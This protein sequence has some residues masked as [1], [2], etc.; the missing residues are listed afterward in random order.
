MK[1]Y[2]RFLIATFLFFVAL[3]IFDVPAYA[4]LQNQVYSSTG[5]HTF[6]VPSGI[7]EITVEAWGGGGS[8]GS[9]TGSTNRAS[10]GGGGAYARIT[11]TVTPNQEITLYVGAGSS[12]TSAGGDSWFMNTATLLAKGGTSANSAIIGVG[13]SAAASNG[14]YTFSGGDGAERAPG[15]SGGGGSS[16]GS[17][18]NGNN[19]NG[20]L[21]GAAPVGG[22]AGGNGLNSAGPGN[23]GGEPGGGGEAEHLARMLAVKVVMGR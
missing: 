16:A 3:F 14:D 4:Q 9:R 2:T 10:G 6:T 23:P 21:G 5:S 17:S 13:G 7:T 22:G 8:G 20:S 15:I 19:G 18:S 12:S 1:I 11:L